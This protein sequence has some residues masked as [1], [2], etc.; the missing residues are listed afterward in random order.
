[1]SELQLYRPTGPDESDCAVAERGAEDEPVILSF[2][3]YAGRLRR[4]GLDAAMRARRLRENRRCPYCHSPVVEP[5][6]LADAV[7]GK[8]RLP[9]PG[10]A[11]LVGFHCDRCA[12]EWPA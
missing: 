10:T 9:I 12:A 5:L 11:T 8:G 7:L 3:F 1:M 2:E 4:R 6:E